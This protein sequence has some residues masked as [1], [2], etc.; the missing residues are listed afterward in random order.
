MCD[1]ATPTLRTACAAHDPVGVAALLA[2]GD[3][4]F[5]GG[6]SM[7]DATLA[8]PGRRPAI[9][10]PPTITKEQANIV[11]LLVAKGLT[12]TTATGGAAAPL[13]ALLRTDPVGTTA[14]IN[15]ESCRCGKQLQSLILSSS[16]S[17]PSPMQQCP[18]CR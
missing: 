12:H 4:T 3:Y 17:H 10:P 11:Q 1:C 5:C 18:E 14:F 16:A 15:Q 6:C 9:A 7:L 8:V 2:A 13:L